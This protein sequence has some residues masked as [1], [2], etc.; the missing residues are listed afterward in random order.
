MSFGISQL[1]EFVKRP[2][3]NLIYLVVSPKAYCLWARLKN[4]KID[5]GLPNIQKFFFF[6][7][8]GKKDPNFF[9]VQVGANDGVNHDP[10]F[11]HVRKYNWKGLLIEPIPDIFEK[12]KYIK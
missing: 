7:T 2:I 3:R 10:I 1:P 12:L 6:S 9:F 11:H 8:I 5:P 4:K